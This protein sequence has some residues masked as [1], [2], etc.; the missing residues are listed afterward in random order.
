MG[1][2]DLKLAESLDCV[3]GIKTSRFCRDQGLR[4]EPRFFDAYAGKVGIVQDQTLNVHF[5]PRQDA[6]LVL[7]WHRVAGR[8]G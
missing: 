5:I 1:I 2:E 3:K 7:R 4:F 8:Q 6:G